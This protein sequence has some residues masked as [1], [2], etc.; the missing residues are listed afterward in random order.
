MLK[1]L[2]IKELCY[3]EFKITDFHTHRDHISSRQ[4][5]V[6]DQG[7]A[8]PAGWVIMAVK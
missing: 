7:G 8:I 6:D 3:S 2:S 1:F 4:L 5:T